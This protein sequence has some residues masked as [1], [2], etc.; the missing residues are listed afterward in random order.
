MRQLT[1]YVLREVLL[2]FT[3]TLVAL[4]GLMVIWGAVQ[5]AIADGL[6]IG[7]IVLLLPYLLPKALM[8]AVPGTILFAV[9]NFYGRMSGNNEIVAL[10]SLGLSPMVVLWPVLILSAVLSLV[11]VWLNDMAASWGERGMQNVV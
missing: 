7:Q 4:T 9:T 3:I 5:K 1:R 8:F 10:K 6:G 11:T 2:V